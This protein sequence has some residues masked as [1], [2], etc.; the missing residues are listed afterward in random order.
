VLVHLSPEHSKPN[1]FQV[2]RIKGVVDI[3]FVIGYKGDELPTLLA[4]SINVEPVGT[5]LDY[6]DSR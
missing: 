1:E 4:E 2:F 5:F 3:H 6:A